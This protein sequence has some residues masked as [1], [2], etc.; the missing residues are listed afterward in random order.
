M[1]GVAVAAFVT[2]ATCAKQ[3]LGAIAALR[4]GAGFTELSGALG[5]LCQR[6]TIAWL[7]DGRGATADGSCWTGG[8][9]DTLLGRVTKLPAASFV[10][11]GALFDAKSIDAVVRGG[12]A[13]VATHRALLGREGARL[14]MEPGGLWGAGA[15]EGRGGV[16][17]TALASLA[18]V[19]ARLGVTALD[20][21]S[22]VAAPGC[23]VKVKAFFIC[24]TA[25]GC[26]VQLACF[27]R[28]DLPVL[29]V[30][31]FAAV[32]GQRLGVEAGFAEFTGALSLGWRDTAKP[33]S[34]A[35]S[36]PSLTVG[37][38]GAFPGVFIGRVADEGTDA[39][40]GSGAVVE[41]VG[42][43]ADAKLATFAGR[44][45]GKAFV[46]VTSRAADPVPGVVAE[47][48]FLPITMARD[49]E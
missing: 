25:R 31:F 11:G 1:P 12:R 47:Q 49:G 38:S 30:E 48:P 29:A 36:D 6:S 34:V 9:A 37:F 17:D 42:L 26:G 16:F 41:Q 18:A 40:E 7:P 35:V 13:G 19:G 21:C 32:A 14:A 39:A 46:G 2:L 10:A 33:I 3:V 44:V 20:A 28:L 43:S 22:Y 23:P 24:A 8:V 27:G 4:Q 45:V 5:F 15:A